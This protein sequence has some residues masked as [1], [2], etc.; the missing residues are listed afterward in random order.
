MD[1]KVCT[2]VC[3]LKKAICRHAFNTHSLNKHFSKP[4]IN[5]AL[6]WPVLGT[7]SKSESHPEELPIWWEDSW[8]ESVPAQDDW[9]GD[10]GERRLAGA[11]REVAGDFPR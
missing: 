4:P 11:Q 1:L 2:G 8:A 9:S 6:G 7:R 5:Q 3:Q 10:R